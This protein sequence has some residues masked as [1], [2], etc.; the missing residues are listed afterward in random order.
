MAN[1]QILILSL[2]G[3]CLRFVVPQRLPPNGCS[4]IFHYERQGD[5]WI[6]HVIP[7]QNGL[8]SVNW[9]LKFSSHG[10]DVPGTV[11]NLAPYPDKETALQRMHDG[12]SA[13][14][15]VRF[16][17]YEGELPKIV[18]IELNGQT[19]CSA[20]SYG[21]PSSTATRQLHLSVSST[22][23]AVG[24]SQPKTAVSQRVAS[25]CSSIFQ[26]ENQGDHWIGHVTPTQN[27]LRDVTWKL[28]FSSHGV[29]NPGT[30]SNLAPYP[31]KDTA[32]Q[33]M[34]DGGSAEVFVS[35]DNFQGQLPKVVLIEMNGQTICASSSYPAPSSTATRQLHL[36]VSSSTPTQTVVQPVSRPQT[37][38]SGGNNNPFLTRRTTKK[39]VEIVATR[40]EPGA[41][42]C[43]VEGFTG[44]QI[45]GENVP[46]GRFPWLA[47]LYHDTNL[48]PTTIE[49][50][51][52]CVSTLISARTVITAA[53]CIYGLTPAQLRVYVGR[54][55]VTVHPEKDATLMAVESVRPHPD[56]NGN[57]V[58]DVDVGLLVLAEHV[59]YS[60]YVRPICLWSSGASLGIDDSEQAAVA[61]WG[62]DSSNKPTRFPTTVN[63]RP[64]SREECLREMVTAKDFLTPRTLCA[65]NSQGHGPCLGDSGGGLMVLRNNRWVVRGIVSLAQR[66]GNSCDLSRYVIYCD[67]A[68]HLSWIKKNV[69]S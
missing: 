44:L 2:F 64:V 58:P 45:G 37:T 33:R 32:L 38:F 66:S 6:G 1:L 19:L 5:H 62:T 25:G 35:F 29:D 50:T 4:N 22:A 16:D 47:A 13:E 69:V 15:F 46:R 17:D 51:Y 42:E 56:F 14:T 18:L 54:H 65:G 7:D 3:L 60:T 49:L 10:A 52:K 21:A 12:G 11:S 40:R 63:V 9:K 43:G 59:T 8:R 41:D 30:V 68:R 39:P 67:V 61:G 31:D 36:S 55:D 34:H 28:K 27:G 53:H 20:S 26:Y 48:D 24:V 57:L 23:T